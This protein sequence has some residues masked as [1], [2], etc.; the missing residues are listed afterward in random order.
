MSTVQYS[1]PGS[2]W[3][4]V[5]QPI[6]EPAFLTR[7]FRLLVSPVLVLRGTVLWQCSD[8]NRM[9]E[10]IQHP[11]FSDSL[12]SAVDEHTRPPWPLGRCLAVL[13]FNTISLVLAKFGSR[14]FLPNHS[15]KSLTSARY[16]SFHPPLRGG[17]GGGEV[18]CIWSQM[19]SK[20]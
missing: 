15:T 12:Q 3:E 17:G 5:Q 9:L 1:K 2:Q 19:E 20:S 4:W 18:I 11:A 8:N 14:W 10:D 6:T 7:W 13:F 16:S